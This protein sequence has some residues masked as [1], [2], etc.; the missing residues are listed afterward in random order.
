MTIIIIRTLPIIM[1]IMLIIIRVLMPKAMVIVI[2]E[3]LVI[4]TI[5]TVILMTY[6]WNSMEKKTWLDEKIGHINMHRDIPY[7]WPHKH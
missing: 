4:A 7:Y 6:Q 2:M 1:V 3:E 5:V